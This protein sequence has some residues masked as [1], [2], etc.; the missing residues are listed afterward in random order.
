MLNSD[1]RRKVGDRATAVHG[2]VL[3]YIPDHPKSHNGYVYEHILIMENFLGR[4]LIDSE[5]VHHDNGIRNDNRKEN[6]VLCK[7]NKEH[8]RI[9]AGWSIINDVWFKKC[10]GCL[11][12]LRVN[13]ENFYKRK[14]KDSYFHVCINCSN[15]LCR[16]KYN[17]KHHV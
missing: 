2:Y 13:E 11:E 8:L 6:L 12:F 15:K 14:N 9:H 1:T 4:Y 16:D 5:I 7:N 10:R 3:I 17:L